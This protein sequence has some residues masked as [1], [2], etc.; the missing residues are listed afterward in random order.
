M[1]EEFAN[2]KRIEMDSEESPI[3]NDLAITFRR[4]SRYSKN[5]P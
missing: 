4:R 1:V 2:E 3:E 5:I